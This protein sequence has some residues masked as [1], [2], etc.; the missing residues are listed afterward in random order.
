MMFIVIQMNYLLQT[1]FRHMIYYIYVC[2]IY[3]QQLSNFEF[4]IYSNDFL[5]GFCL[6]CWP[7][8]HTSTQQHIS[9]S[10]SSVMLGPLTIVPNYF[11]LNSKHTWRRLTKY[12][13]NYV[14][15]IYIH[16]M[17]WV[18]RIVNTI[19]ARNP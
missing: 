10:V 12:W 15:L 11:F 3:L 7:L 9:R 1:D 17:W 19:I 2:E 5:G 13:Y 16:S 4:I 6:L 8:I 18:Y 14:T